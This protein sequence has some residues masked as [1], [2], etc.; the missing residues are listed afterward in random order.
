MNS[1]H[2]GYLDPGQTIINYAVRE[3]G[4]SFKDVV[5]DDPSLLLRNWFK[6]YRHA[7]NTVIGTGIVGAIT[8]LIGVGTGATPLLISGVLVA[9]GSG[10]L[11]KRQNE[12]CQSCELESDILNEIRPVLSLFVQLEEKGAAAS[13]LVSLYD[14]LIKRISANPMLAHSLTGGEGLK[15]FLEAE[16]RKCTLLS[17]VASDRSQQELRLTRLPSFP[18]TSCVIAALKIQ[19][20]YVDF[21]LSCR[22]ALSTIAFPRCG[23]LKQC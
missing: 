22:Q 14:R 7:R 5:A 21:S 16:L 17:H 2:N 3:L 1:E 4:M 13:D 23:T 12:G 10:V 6:C 8:I 20:C 9:G 19:L 15:A 11:V 18:Q